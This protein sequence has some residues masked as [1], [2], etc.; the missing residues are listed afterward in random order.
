VK[1]P[2][3]NGGPNSTYEQIKVVETSPTSPHNEA[4]FEAGKALLIQSIEIGRDFCKFM[5]SICAGAIPVYLGLLKFVLPESHTFTTWQGILMVTPL[6][7]FA[8]ALVVFVCG[9]FPQ[10][11]RFSLDVAEVIEE[12]RR[13]TISRRY[14]CSWLGFCIFLVGLV[15]GALAI[16]SVYAPSTGASPP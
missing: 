14:T 2:N 1:N 10:R 9:F 12:E 3:N 7:L 8:C 13:T 16:I 15:V 4:L 11:S 5:I 6:L